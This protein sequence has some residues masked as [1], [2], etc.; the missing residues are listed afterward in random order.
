MTIN[1]EGRHLVTTDGP[2]SSTVSGLGEA[3][4]TSADVATNEPLTGS[5]VIGKLEEV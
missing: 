4:D 5:C 2:R 3:V 1:N